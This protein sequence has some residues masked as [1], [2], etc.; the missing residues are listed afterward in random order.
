M[1]LVM[2]APFINVLA[3]LGGARWLGAYAA[4]AALAMAAVAIAVV[5]TGAL[6]RAIGPRRTR[7]IAQILAAVVGA[8]FA[9]GVQFA[10]IFS[11]GTMACRDLAPW[12]ASSRRTATASSGGRPAPFSASRRRWRLCWCISVAALA[13]AIVVFAPRF[14]RFALAAASV[15]IQR[16]R[17]SRRQCALPSG[18][19]PRRRCGARSGRCCCAIPG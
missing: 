19:R 10:A 9:I 2:A 5:I 7:F 8:A 13:A 3:W 6:F 4:A 18:R 14:G 16:D 12:L 17:R 11:Y 1:S 15:V